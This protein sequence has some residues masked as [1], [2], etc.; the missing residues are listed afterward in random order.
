MANRL[1]GIEA[2]SEAVR[3]TLISAGALGPTDT[4]VGQLA[5]P[6]RPDPAMIGLSPPAAGQR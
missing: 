2:V 1:S 3:F 6:L 5:Y 4:I